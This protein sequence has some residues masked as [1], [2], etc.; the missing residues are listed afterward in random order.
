[1][2]NKLGYEVYG[3]EYLS[4][5]VWDYTLQGWCPNKKD[6]LDYLY[7]II[8]GCQFVGGGIKDL[9]DPEDEYGDEKFIHEE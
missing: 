2:S 7:D 1:M 5:D 4:D 3:Y 9:D 6:A 8:D